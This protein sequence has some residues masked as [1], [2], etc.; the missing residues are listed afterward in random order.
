[1]FPRPVQKIHVGFEDPDGKGY[2][3]F[4]A[5]YKEIEEVL[6]PKVKEALFGM[7][8]EVSQLKGGVSIKFSGAVQK[9][10]I[11]KMVQNCK[12]GTCECMSDD[13]KKKITDMEVSGDDG[14]VL[15][16]LSGDVKKEEI[17]AALAKSKV[18]QNNC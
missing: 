15:L 2:E 5:T 3:A 17:E 16:E 4:L 1:M 13:T 14:E 9:Q 18:C 12:T 11:V 7:K 6:L 8:K 10:N